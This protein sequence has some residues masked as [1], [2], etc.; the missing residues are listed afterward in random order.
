LR[1]EE[2]GEINLLYPFLFIKLYSSD[3]FINKSGCTLIHVFFYFF[4]SFI[5]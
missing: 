4:Y 5:S 3:L 1:E 2:E